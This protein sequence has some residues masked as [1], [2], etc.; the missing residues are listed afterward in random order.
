MKKRK[1]FVL[2]DQVDAILPVYDQ[3]GGNICHTLLSSGDT[4]TM[5]VT[6]YHLL[7]QWLRTFRLTTHGQRIWAQSM[8]GHRNLNPIVIHNNLT[9]IPIK[10]RDP[11]SPKDGAYGYV[12]L[13]SIKGIDPY[14]ILLHS[15]TRILYLS[16]FQVLQNKILQGEYLQYKFN[17]E[18]ISL[19]NLSKTNNK[20][21]SSINYLGLLYYL[22]NLS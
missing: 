15:N 10:V 17:M 9:L 18:L 6:I 22:D 3:Y 2:S 4:Q 5:P 11:I 13:S 1:D 8:T 12:K 20:E 19:Y 14:S 7:E 16:S 21:A